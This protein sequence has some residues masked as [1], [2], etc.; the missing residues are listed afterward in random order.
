MQKLGTG[1]VI[2]LLWFLLPGCS[3]LSVSPGDVMKAPGSQNN[4]EQVR[5]LVEDFLPAGAQLIIPRQPADISAIRSAN[6]CGNEEKELVAF[7][8]KDYLSI[9]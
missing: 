1:I 7:Y 5:K 6:I 4:E 9:Y 2:L 3:G 8:K